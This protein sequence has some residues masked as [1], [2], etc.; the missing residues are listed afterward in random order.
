M[1]LF[2][3]AIVFM[4]I[5]AILLWAGGA[6]GKPAPLYIVKCIWLPGVFGSLLLAAQPLQS[7]HLDDQWFW[8][9]FWAFNVPFVVA[10]ILGG[11]LEFVLL[12]GKVGLHLTVN[13]IITVVYVAV[14]IG[15]YAFAF[16]SSGRF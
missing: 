9:P 3:I 13:K 4:L 6:D 5:T 16:A 15:T 8:G 14:V 11:V 1:A 12:R 10:M 7:T 2:P